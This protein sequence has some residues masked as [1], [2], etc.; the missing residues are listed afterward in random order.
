VYAFIGPRE[1]AEGNSAMRPDI[2]TQS[3]TVTDRLGQ[4]K[5]LIE[6]SLRSPHVVSRDGLRITVQGTAIVSAEET[7]FR[8]QGVASTAT[9]GDRFLLPEI[10]RFYL[11]DRQEVDLGGNFN[12]AFVRAQEA[13]VQVVERAQADV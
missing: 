6:F 5:V 11:S 13:F 7:G 2:H 12:E 8:G 10:K 4:P 9:F 1:R 3:I